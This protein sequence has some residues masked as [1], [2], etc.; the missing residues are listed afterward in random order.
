VAQKIRTD[1]S[2]CRIGPDRYP[3]GTSPLRGRPEGDHSVEVSPTSV[4]GR[5]GEARK[6][7]D[8]RRWAGCPVYRRDLPPQV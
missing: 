1:R 5:R 2:T 7:S 6:A 4:L 3:A 8:Q